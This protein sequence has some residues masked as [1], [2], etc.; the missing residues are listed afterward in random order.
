MTLD[1][2]CDQ[3]EL[4]ASPGQQKLCAARA[5][6]PGFDQPHSCMNVTQP[7]Q[8]KKPRKGGARE[9]HA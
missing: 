3:T 1:M 6:L 7:K 9:G 8:A 2:A 5:A 4:L